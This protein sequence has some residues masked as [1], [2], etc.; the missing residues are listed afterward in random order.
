MTIACSSRVPILRKGRCYHCSCSECVQLWTI[1]DWNHFRWWTTC[2]FWM[3]LVFP[4]VKNGERKSEFW[5]KHRSFRSISLIQTWA[6]QW[7][8][9]GNLRSITSQDQID[10]ATTYFQKPPSK[11]GDIIVDFHHPCS[12][13]AFGLGWKLLKIV[14]V[15]LLPPSLCEGCGIPPLQTSL[16]CDVWVIN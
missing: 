16:D 8:C 6:K 9:V 3:C 13:N 5:R 10:N 2:L 14:Y 1:C 12:T 15:L 7:S 11:W 4:V